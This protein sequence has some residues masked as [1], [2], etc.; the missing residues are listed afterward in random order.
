MSGIEAAFIAVLGRDA[1]IKTSKA[2]RDY[3]RLACR[4][5][6]ADSSVWVSIMA[7]EPDVIAIIGGLTKGSKLYVECRNLK[8]DEWEGK[9]GAKRNGLSAIASYVRI[10][11]IGVNRPQKRDGDG[12]PA[13]TQRAT[14]ARDDELSDDTIPF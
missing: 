4:V 13:P 11:A 9:D 7:F 12:A 14:R 5:G 10:P 6:D 3:A 8:I 2:G 1:E